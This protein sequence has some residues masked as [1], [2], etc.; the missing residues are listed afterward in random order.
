MDLRHTIGEFVI[1]AQELLERLR[2]PWERE[3]L[4]DVD[5]KMLRVQLFLV[6]SEVANLQEIRRQMHSQETTE[7]EERKTDN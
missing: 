6:D 5:L 7:G 2:T 4:H 3:T 1:D